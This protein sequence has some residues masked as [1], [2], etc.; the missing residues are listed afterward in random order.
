MFDGRESGS[1]K[2]QS[3]PDTL[4]SITTFQSG[5]C[6]YFTQNKIYRDLIQIQ[7]TQGLS[8]KVGL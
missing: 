3:G 1:Q 8:G 6:F 7:V 4:Q 5:L 2:K